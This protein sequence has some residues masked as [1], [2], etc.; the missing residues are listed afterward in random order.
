MPRRAEKVRALTTNYVRKR[1][2]FED[3]KRILDSNAEDDDKVHKIEK[4][5]EELYE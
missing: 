3:I 4:I 1:M 2:A 5:L